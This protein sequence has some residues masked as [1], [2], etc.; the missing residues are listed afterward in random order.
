MSLRKKPLALITGASSG[1]GVEL[2]RVFA[3]NG[4]DLVLVARRQP[5]LERFAGELSTAHHCHCTV[6]PC[7]LTEP[8]AVENL[9][10]ALP[11]QPLDVLINNA[12]VMR[13]VDF[14]TDDMQR[15]LQQISLN[16]LAL[17]ELTHRCLQPML[18]RGTGRI[19]NLASVAGFQPVPYMSVYAA[20]KAYVL[21]FSEGLS[22]EL[23][24]TGVTCT[25]I[26]PG[27]TDTPMLRGRKNPDRKIAPLPLGLIADPAFVAR[28]AYK[29]IMNGEVIMV[30]G[31]IYKA[32][33]S[34][35]SIPPR[36][37]VRS[38]VGAVGRRAKKNT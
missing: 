19:A 3:G 37:L 36:S 9:M 38:L 30:P 28:E 23:R 7:D 29:A 21:S 13:A 20:T 26:C 4:F 15:Q 12:G 25:A 34:L 1:I 2:A 33:S 6:V 31:L 16:V 32:M 5:E 14:S 27:F 35:S 22:E 8:G 18:K 10:H 17:T 24:G 11:A